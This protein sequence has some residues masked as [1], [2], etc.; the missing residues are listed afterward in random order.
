[1]SYSI[2]DNHW[3]PSPLIKIRGWGSLG[4]LQNSNLKNFH[5]LNH[6]RTANKAMHSK[7]T[8]EYVSPFVSTANNL[9]KLRTKNAKA[10]LAA[11]RQKVN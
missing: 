3:G 7:R 10:Y 9:A 1:M 8:K 6:Y 4:G 2:N 5:E 11:E